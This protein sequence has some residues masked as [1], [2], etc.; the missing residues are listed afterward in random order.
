M[1]R[2][3]QL[4]LLF[5]IFSP[6]ASYSQQKGKLVLKNIA[7]PSLSN[8]IIGEPVNQPIAVYLP[9]SYEKE[10]QKRYPVVYFLPGFHTP[11]EAYTGFSSYNFESSMNSNI[12]QGRLKEVIMVIVNGFNILEGCFYN[13]SPVTGNWEDFVVKDVVTYIDKT[14]RTIPL[15]ESRVLMGMSMGGYGALHLSMKHPSVFSIGLGHCPGLA[16]QTG[17]M[18]TSLF[19]DVN[20]IKRIISI[21]NYLAQY[22]KVEA[23]QKYL[24]TIQY[25]SK[26]GD[27][28]TLF[29]FAYGSAFSPDTNINA[30]YFGYPFSLNK[31]NVLIK[32]TIIFKNYE[33]GF[34]N[35]SEKLDLY[36]DSLLK[37]RGYAI[38]YGTNDNFKWI[39]EGCIY[40]DSLLT[41]KGIPHHVWQNNG[42]HGDLLKTR[43]ENFELPYCDTILTF[44]TNYLSNS[45]VIEIFTCPS[46]TSEPII[47]VENKTIFISLKPGANLKYI[48]PTIFLAPGAKITPSVNTIID[49]TTGSA[50]YSVNSENGKNNSIWTIQTE[51]STS[52]K[53][54]SN[55]NQ[56]FEIFPNPVCNQFTISSHQINIDKI[57]LVDSFGRLI[58]EHIVNSKQITLERNNIP[59]G[60]YILKAY[61]NNCCYSKKLIIK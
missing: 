51:L 57:E 23:H 26:E 33:K 3:L 34:G 13:N 45:A 9:P 28:I 53:I 27:W 1:K 25:F 7:S 54:A 58:S 59:S 50:T 16:N 48:R 12:T 31:D 61:S 47:D 29:S 55:Q 18:K 35:L 56:I 6:I 44:D 24:D 42:G 4:L 11:I 10:P 38:D 21:K 49:L 37:L 17:M 20:V 15:A 46:Q 22:S 39:P 19:D 5:A 30:P 2:K 36:K 14:Y 32:D 8:S 43:T 60:V 41:A 40:Y 52:I